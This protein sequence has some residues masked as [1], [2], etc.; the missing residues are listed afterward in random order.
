MLRWLFTVIEARDVTE[1]VPALTEIA[2]SCS[3]APLLRGMALRNLALYTYRTQ[4]R[5]AL[6]MLSA[7]AFHHGDWQAREMLDL[8]GQRYTS[9]VLPLSLEFCSSLPVQARKMTEVQR[10]LYFLSGRAAA[11]A[12]NITIPDRWSFIATPTFLSSIC[13]KN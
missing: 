2:T 3:L 12:D 10:W 13:S 11:A 4:P 5:H 7:S 6:A 8:L 1:L 9:S